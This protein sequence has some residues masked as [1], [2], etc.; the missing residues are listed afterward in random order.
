MKYNKP[1]LTQFELFCNGW[2]NT[3]KINTSLN[4]NK[5]IHQMFLGNMNKHNVCCS[6]SK[7]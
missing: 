7:D 3:S 6:A 4:S 1:S 2:L 5:E